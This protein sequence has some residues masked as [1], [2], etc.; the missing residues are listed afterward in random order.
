MSS[1]RRSL[2]RGAAPGAGTVRAFLRSEGGLALTRSEAER[3]CRRLLKAAG[4]PQPNVNQRIEGYLVDFLWPEQR[5]ILELDTYTF[6]GN[7]RAFERDRRKTM[8]LEDAGYIVIRVTRRQLV[9][10]PY[11]VV[12]HVARALDRRSRLI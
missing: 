9:E 10:E 12:A 2:A 11:L 6:H 5:V 7:R 8:M 3:R 4:L 1:R